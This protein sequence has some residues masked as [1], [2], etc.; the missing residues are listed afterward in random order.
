MQTILAIVVQQWY[1]HR[2]AISS[3]NR[4]V[5][6]ASDTFLS[7]SRVLFIFICNIVIKNERQF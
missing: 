1:K 7:C 2:S 4:I 3:N 6:V 5:L